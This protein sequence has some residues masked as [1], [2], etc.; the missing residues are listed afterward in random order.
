MSKNRHP[1]FHENTDSALEKAYADLRAL[2]ATALQQ[3]RGGHTLQPTA[4]VHEVYLK[5][6]DQDRAAW[7]DRLHFIRV[8]SSQIRRILV[9]HARTRGRQKRGGDLVRVTLSE[10][11]PG[12]EPDVDILDLDRA[13]NRLNVRAPEDRALVELKFFGGLTEPEIAQVLDINERTVRRRWT[14]VRAWLHREL[15]EPDS[16]DSSGGR[17]P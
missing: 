8:A 14:F 11:M 4:L 15:S 1:D 17:A 5:L 3:E 9:D 6:A 2:A 13:L 10:D 12:V 16:S 7:V